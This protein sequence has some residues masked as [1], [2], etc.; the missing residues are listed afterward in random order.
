[1]SAESYREVVPTLEQG[2]R[3][4]TELLAGALPV[5]SLLVTHWLFR[6]LYPAPVWVGVL[7]ALA[8]GAASYAAFEVWRH[9]RMSKRAPTEPNRA[10]GAQTASAGAAIKATAL[11]AVAT[12]GILIVVLH[13]PGWLFGDAVGIGVLLLVWCVIFAV[14]ARQRRQ[15]TGGARLSRGL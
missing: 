5:V 1:M 15:G 3:D 7:A 12:V 4:T 6:V 10:G 11:G 2:H 9:S 13:V 8:A 14:E